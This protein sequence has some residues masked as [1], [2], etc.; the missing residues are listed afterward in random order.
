[1]DYRDNNYSKPKIERKIVRLTRKQQSREDAKNII[2][3][4]IALALTFVMVTVMI[5][6]LASKTIV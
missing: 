3:T 1:M 6:Q 5:S 4:G 2:V